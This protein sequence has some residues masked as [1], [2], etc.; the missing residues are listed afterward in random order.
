MHPCVPLP[1]AFHKRFQS[2][3]RSRRDPAGQDS[4]LKATQI[5]FRLFSTCMEGKGQTAN[6]KIIMKYAR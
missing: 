5:Q 1:E 4:L 3:L 2:P 6:L